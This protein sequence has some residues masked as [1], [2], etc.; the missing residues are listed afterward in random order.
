MQVGS[1]CVFEDK[2]GV[3]G[4]GNDFIPID[5]KIVKVEVSKLRELSK[6]EKIDLGSG[7]KR[8]IKKLF[9][10]YVNYRQY[11]PSWDGSLELTED[12]VLLVKTKKL[13]QLQ[14]RTVRTFEETAKAV[15]TYRYLVGLNPMPDAT[16]ILEVRV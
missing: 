4:Q 13:A 10:I 3:K 14:K 7:K 12:R 6:E 9:T 5:G 11:W 2:L 1:F 8:R 16:K 15:K